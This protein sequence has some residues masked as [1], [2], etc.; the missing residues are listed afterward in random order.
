MNDVKGAVEPFV[1]KGQ[2]VVTVSLETF[3]QANTVVVEG[4]QELF[5]TNVDAGKDLFAAAQTS[6]EKAR[7]DG[8]KAVASKPIEYIPDGREVVVA[9]YKDSFSIVSKTGEE[10]FSV[11][12][13]G[14]EDVAAKLT[15]STT[16]SG[17]VKKAKS[18]A[19]KTV[20]KATTGAKKAAAQ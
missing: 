3:K 16:V 8:L 6:F 15:G 11:V 7:T 12:K 1:A 2:D 14:Y 18:T 20:K 5:K 9:A 17:E 10:L 13:K 19:R 4:V